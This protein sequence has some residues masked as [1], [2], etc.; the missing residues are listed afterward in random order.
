MPSPVLPALTF[1]A[2]MEICIPS[3]SQCP[4][5]GQAF[6]WPVLL[7]PQHLQVLG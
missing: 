7:G 6:R 2:L 5:D 1:Q 3:L 4:Q